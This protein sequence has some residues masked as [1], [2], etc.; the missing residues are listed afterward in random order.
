MVIIADIGS[1]TLFRNPV[2]CWTFLVVISVNAAATASA[3]CGGIC[4]AKKS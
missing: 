4:F 1:A 3:W 2:I